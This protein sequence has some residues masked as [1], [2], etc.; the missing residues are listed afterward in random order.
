MKH[1][2]SFIRWLDK[3]CFSPSGALAALALF[4]MT[5]LITVDVIGRHFEY[6]TGVAHEFSGYSLVIIVFLGLAYTQ[7]VAKHVEIDV[8]ITRL[9]PKWRWVLKLVTSYIGLAFVIWLLWVTLQR[10]IRAYTLGSVS[11]T[12]LRTPLWPIQLL[13]PLG[14]GLLAMAIMAEII[15]HNQKRDF[16]K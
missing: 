5:L 8:V 2:L 1:L 14:L 15:K 11:M 12:L 7:R 16:T 4:L 10:V 9:P 3:W 13:I 6:P